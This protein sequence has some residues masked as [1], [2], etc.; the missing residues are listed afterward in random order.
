MSWKYQISL[1][2]LLYHLATLLPYWFFNLEELPIDVSAVLK[3]PTII[4]FSSISLFI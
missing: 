2:D 3:Y 1:T 4:V